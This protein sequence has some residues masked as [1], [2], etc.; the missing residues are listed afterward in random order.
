[1]IT[2][3]D[4]PGSDEEMFEEIIVEESNFVVDSV[5]E[6]KEPGSDLL[7]EG[8]DETVDVKN[9]DAH[10]SNDLELSREENNLEVSNSDQELCADDNLDKVVD[11]I[12]KKVDLEEIVETSE[13]SSASV[14]GL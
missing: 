14:Q 3:D 9:L 4:Q 6:S 12:N 7:V 8:T 1:M 5:A 10:N 11:E 13:Q 2:S